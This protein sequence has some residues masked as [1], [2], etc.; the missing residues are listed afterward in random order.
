MAQKIIGLD[1]GE[2]SLR[3]VVLDAGLRGYEVVGSAIVPLD[4]PTP[5]VPAIAIA[6]AE[7]DGSEPT[8]EA[9]PPDRLALALETLGAQIGG[10]K[11][12]VVAV[13]LPGGQTA[14]SFVTLPF[15]ESK[16]IDATLGFE[17][18]NLLP[19]DLDEAVFDY[20]LVS[21]RDGKSELLV[22]VAR[23]DEVRSL[24]ERLRERGVDP[25]VMTLPGL[26]NLALLTELGSREK[27][28]ADATEGLLDLGRDRTILSIIRGGKDER[29]PPSL[30]FVRSM[31]GADEAALQPM[32]REIRQTLFSAQA[33]SR[34]PLQRLRLTGELAGIEGLAARLSQALGVPV[35]HLGQLPGDTTGAI[36][37]ERR[38]TLAQA[39]GLALRGHAR[40]RLLNLRKGA[41][42][43]RG[44]LDYLKGKVS[45]L[46]GFAAVLLLL[47]GANVWTQLH[48][49]GEQEAAL[50]QALCES[51]Q[52][53]LGS[54]ETDFNLALSKLQG[55]DTKASQIP[56]ASALEVF[57]EATNRVPS[58]VNLRVDEIDVALD[59][60]RVR[61]VVDSFDE[62][63]QVVAELRKS[64][65]I[66]D[67][68]PGRVQKNR[69]ERIEF[70]L[71]A[72]YVCGQN[73]DK[74]G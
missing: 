7:V 2:E 64:R 65:C 56:T 44:D 26:A 31:G 1:L 3:A 40:G 50:D 8:Q 38:D 37:A 24:L 14:T 13:A 11:A 18:E 49:L 60:L 59:R 51:T 34:I 35:E 28:P 52:R 66:G 42:A 67:V 68:K 45:R 39:F 25:R 17:V 10:L 57:S 69:E 33:R 5:A 72:L 19:F 15:T 43:Y 54:C 4:P 32:I 71:D 70:T 36:P 27:L 74:A 20:Q 23:E 61:G 46:V 53:V 22:G 30:A 63:D 29:H 58:G 21:Q 9:A 16:K 48:I 12:D 73:A 62:V 55:G 6:V 41:F 47:V